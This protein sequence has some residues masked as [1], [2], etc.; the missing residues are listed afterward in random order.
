MQKITHR[1]RLAVYLAV[2]GDHRH[3]VLWP[4][5]VFR[6]IYEDDETYFQFQFQTY[7]ELDS[8]VHGAG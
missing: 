5:H 7:C 3:H 1:F 4:T 2:M 6:L 8:I